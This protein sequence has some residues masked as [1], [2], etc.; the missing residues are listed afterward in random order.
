MNNRELSKR[1]LEKV[2][3][4]IAISNFQKEKKDMKNYRIL[5]MVAMFTIVIGLTAGMVYAGNIIYENVFKKPKKIENFIEELKVSDE[6]LNK[7]ITE[8]EAK[9]KAKEEIKKFGFN[10]QDSDIQQIELSKDPNYDLITYNIM[11]SNNLTIGI[12]AIDGKINNFYFEPNYTLEEKEKFTTTKEN[13]IQ[14]AEKKI[15]E[16]GFGD[17]YK[18]ANVLSNN[19][20]DESKSY[21]WYIT[22]AKQY[23]GIFNETQSISITIIPKVNVVTSFN[24][25]DE[26]FDNNPINIS[27]EEAIKIAKEKD[28]IINTENYVIKNV[29]AELAIKRMNGNIYFKENGIENQVQSKELEDGTIYHYNTYKLNGKARKVFVVK[30]SYEDKPVNQIREYYIDSTTGEVIGGKI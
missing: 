9:N 20:D 14:E 4:K 2:E 30:I 22:F 27:K 10:I 17:D 23:D 19:V 12:N 5:K 8:E 7:I 24:I 6:E 28:K 16:Y 21:M 18:L 1:I 15:K 26:P 29:E 13:I 25:I 3:T 11:A